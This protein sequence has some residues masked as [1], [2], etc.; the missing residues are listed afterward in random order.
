VGVDAARFTLLTSS[1]DSAMNFDIELVKRQSMDNPVYYVQYGHARIASILRKAA[2]Q[3][4]ELRP[5][6]EADLSLLREEGELD[7]LRALAEVPAQIATA[8]DL[9][10]PYRLT[11]AAQDLAGR[12]HRFYAEHRV[13]DEHAPDLTQARLWLCAGTKQALANLLTLLGVS[14]P[15]RMDR[16]D[17]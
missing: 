5:I 13:V 11:H 4:V 10:A 15:E 8:A 2:A 3:G 6:D 9:R 16:T 14:A 7:L 1:N 12:F 17:D